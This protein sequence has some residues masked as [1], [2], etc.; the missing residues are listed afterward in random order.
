MVLQNKDKLYII[1][2]RLL[3]KIS[4]IDNEFTFAFHALQYLD[5][6][7]CEMQYYILETRRLVNLLSVRIGGL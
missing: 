6:K 2:S 4:L 7:D 5:I 3:D 1:Y